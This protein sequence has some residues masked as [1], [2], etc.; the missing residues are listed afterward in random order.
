MAG[1]RKWV[2]AVFMQKTSAKNYEKKSASM[3]EMLYTVFICG[4]T[5]T[6]KQKG[7]KIS[8][9]LSEQISVK[10]ADVLQ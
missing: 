9:L 1:V 8:V 5:E 10:E 2:P 3:R 6:G 7:L 4:L